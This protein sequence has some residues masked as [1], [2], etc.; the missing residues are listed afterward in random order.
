MVGS[1]LQAASER[2]VVVV[3][4]FIASAAVLV[5]SRIAPPVLRRCVLPSPRARHARPLVPGAEP[6]SFWLRG[7][8]RRSAWHC[9]VGLRHPEQTRL[10]RP[11]CRTKYEI[12]DRSTDV[13]SAVTGTDRASFEDLQSVLRA[14]SGCVTVGCFPGGDARL[15]DFP[16]NQTCFLGRRWRAAGSTASAARQVAHHRARQRA[17]LLPGRR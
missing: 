9:S 15:P 10:G 5:A 8:R 12:S 16:D 7:R 3:D 2:R 6:S 1:V 17:A 13:L 14:G 11:G 4:S